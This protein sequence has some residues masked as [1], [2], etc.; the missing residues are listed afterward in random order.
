MLV[1]AFGRYQ[2]LLSLTRCDL[3]AHRAR[4]H[5]PHRAYGNKAGD[6]EEEEQRA[7]VGFGECIDG[8]HHAHHQFGYAAPCGAIIVVVP[9]TQ[10]AGFT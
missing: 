8:Q 9:L 2:T 4:G 1:P 3:L 6:R 10:P 5:R 7:P